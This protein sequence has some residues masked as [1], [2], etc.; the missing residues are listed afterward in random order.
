LN[1]NIS[2]KKAIVCGSSRGL[3]KACAESLAKEGV[4]IIING[5]NEEN[6]QNT[7]KEFED[8]GFKVQSVLGPMEDEN[9]RAALLKACP[10]PDILINNSGGPPPGNF[11]EWSEDDFLSAIKSNFTQSAMLMQSVLPGMKERKFG[12]IINILSAMVKNPHVIMGLSTSARS[13]L[14]GLSKGL[15]REMAQFNI[16]IN[17]LLPERIDTDR[18]TRVI[19]FQAKLAGISYDEAKNNMEEELTAKRMGTVEEFS[20]LAAFLCSEQAAYISGQSISIDGGN[21]TNFY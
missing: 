6:L 15:S 10:E 12:R 5:V 18:Q 2:G 16:T 3:G 14:L 20:D 19:E 8:K 11:F 1:L 7:K 9:T 13:G 17:N 21:S 4:E